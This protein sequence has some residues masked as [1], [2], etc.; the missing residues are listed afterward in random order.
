MVSI[1]DVYTV[2]V[3][4]CGYTNP[5]VQKAR[6]QYHDI[7][8]SLLQPAVARACGN[9]D[10]RVSRP[11]QLSISGWDTVNQEYPD[12]LEG[13]DAIIISGSPNGAYE[14]LEW[15]HRLNKYVAGK[16]PIIL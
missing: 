3:L 10:S 7:F 14:D 11:V 9:I 15:I 2:A 4:N 16:L 5:I 13:I 12:T 6:G 1:T 8:N